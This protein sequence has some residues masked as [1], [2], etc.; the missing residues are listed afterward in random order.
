MDKP[1]RKRDLKARWAWRL[2]LDILTGIFGHGSC[3]NRYETLKNLDYSRN[4]GLTNTLTC[5]LL[6]HCPPSVHI[7]FDKFSQGTLL[8]DSG[9]INNA[10]IANGAQIEPHAGKCGNAVNLLGTSINSAWYPVS[11]AWNLYPF[12]SILVSLLVWQGIGCLTKY[13]VHQRTLDRQKLYFYSSQN[14]AAW[15][16]QCCN[17]SI[18]LSRRAF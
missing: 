7:S 6:A 2:C 9:S 11:L 16:Y 3:Y 15:I 18:S 1:D 12:S 5:P 10:F 17:T 4:C 14:F 13:A 8:D